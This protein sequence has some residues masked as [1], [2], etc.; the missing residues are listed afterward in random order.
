PR[1]A[2]PVRELDPPGPRAL[3]VRLAGDQGRALAR[4]IRGAAAQA[5]G[6]AEDHAG[7]REEAVRARL[8]RRVEDHLPERRAVLEEAVSVRRGAERH[9]AVDQRPEG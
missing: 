8:A 1:A 5:R 7:E 6:A 3:R 2:R 4:G 9:D